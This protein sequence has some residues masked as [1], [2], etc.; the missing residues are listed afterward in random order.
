MTLHMCAP[1]QVKK[2]GAID[3]SA[4]ESEAEMEEIARIRK[5]TL[6]IVAV[7]FFLSMI[8]WPLLMLP[9]GVFRWA[10]LIH[11][12]HSPPMHALYHLPT[13]VKSFFQVYLIKDCLCLGE[14]RSCSDPNFVAVATLSVDF[15]LTS[16][17]ASCLLLGAI[18]RRL[19]PGET[20]IADR[21]QQLQ[22][23]SC[24]IV[25]VELHG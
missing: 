13:D 14:G 15:L 2:A 12:P 9:A 19:H 6:I 8:V 24:G 22:G 4:V 21:P 18:C 16:T 23:G 11:K 7:I 17:S 5:P 3:G 1:A 25:T 20:P 10:T